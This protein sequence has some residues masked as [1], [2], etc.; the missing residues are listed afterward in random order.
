MD[1]QCRAVQPRTVGEGQPLQRVAVAADTGQW[2]LKDGDVAGGQHFALILV[3]LE[4]GAQAHHDIG[5][6][7][8]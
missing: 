8:T 1:E 6:E 7:P 3:Q 4:V 5:T 2:L